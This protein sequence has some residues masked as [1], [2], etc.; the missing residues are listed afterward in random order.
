MIPCGE[1]ALRLHS[2]GENEL[3]LTLLPT[4]SAPSEDLDGVFTLS[5]NGIFFSTVSARNRSIADFIF[6]SLDSAAPDFEDA[7]FNAA[8]KLWRDEIGRADMVAG[9]LLALAS[10][11][12]DVISA[13]SNRILAGS[14]LWN[15]LHL[16]EAAIPFLNEMPPAS[17]I[18]LLE[19]VFDRLQ[20]DLAGG[21]IHGAIEDWYASRPDPAIVLH[22]QVL[23]RLTPQSSSLLINAV[24]AISRSNFETAT[25]MALAD[26][27]SDDAIRSSAGVWTAGRMI[28]AG[29]GPLEY[30]VALRTAIL[31]QLE[32]GS[33]LPRAQAI[34]AA[35]RAVLVDGA[36]EL[37]VRALCRAEDQQM[38][39]ALTQQMSF[40]CTAYAD[41]NDLAQLLEDVALLAPVV[42]GDG[43]SLDHAL[44][45][46]ARNTL[47]QAAVIKYLEKWTQR[48]GRR[49]GYDKLVAK[50]FPET[51]SI[52][53][54]DESMS[55]RV[56]TNWLLAD[57]PTLPAQL[58][59]I[60]ERSTGSLA[61]RLDMSILR[62][63]QEADIVFL[64]RR[65]LGFLHDRKHLTSLVLSLLESSDAESKFY[66]LVRT[67]M[68]SEIGYDYPGS[69]IAACKAAVEEMPEHR[70]LLNAMVADLE[71]GEAA[72]GALPRAKEL[73]PPMHLRRMFASARAKQMGKALAEADKKSIFFQ[74]AKRITIK[75]GRGMFAY[76]QGEFSGAT[77]MHTISHE[78]ELPR[79]EVF[80]PVGCA[81]RR[82]HFQIATR[83][84]K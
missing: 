71:D 33:A 29:D 60:L 50:N 1:F 20:N 68:V 78:I 32:S 84:E 21:A 47:H 7:L 65:M 55:R 26:I 40:N 72:L 58:Q 48:H 24:F 17:L 76:R 13:A 8:Y 80:D 77:Q 62:E 67:M 51:I 12:I 28:L 35:A 57:S 69:T 2:L 45:F 38:L 49:T 5:S 73:M 52:V 9:R 4:D 19:V 43:S 41:R 79:R 34:R 64:A 53:G 27:L 70:D 59:E 11:T 16:L 25:A 6:D 74:L 54:S 46:F 44:A 14:D 66:S 61:P 15:T 82:L 23:E 10:K 56:V 18:S 39:F 3:G 36:F 30:S 22:T 63:L 37:P 81:I 75:A 42:H 31:Q 83:G